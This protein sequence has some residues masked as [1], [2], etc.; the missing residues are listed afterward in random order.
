[1]A[2]TQLACSGVHPPRPEERLTPA[3]TES[4]VYYDSDFGYTRSF[5]RNGS[6]FTSD[7][8]SIVQEKWTA[9]CRKGKC[10]ILYGYWFYKNGEPDRKYEE[11]A[12]GTSLGKYIAAW[13]E[14]EKLG[15]WSMRS[16]SPRTI[17]DDNPKDADEAFIRIY[18]DFDPEED[19]YVFSARIKNRTHAYEVADV[20]G[21]RD[22]TRLNI[23][24]AMNH[25]FGEEYT[26]FRTS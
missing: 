7:G 11:H 20:A 24:D 13:K 26:D 14:L 9:V 23:L 12:V 19:V 2:V 15:I 5:R 3:H 22:R 6:I 16:V 10:T 18:R 17:I 4:S 25:F 8:K 21:L 1:M